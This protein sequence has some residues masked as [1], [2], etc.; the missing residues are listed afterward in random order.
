[1]I[2]ELSEDDKAA[3]L[4]VLT[5]RVEFAQQLLIAIQA[6][7][8]EKKELSALQIRQMASLGNSDLTRLLEKV[9]GKIGVSSEDAKKQIAKIRN[10]YTTAPLWAY[11]AARGEQVYKKNCAACHPR[12]GTSVPLGPGLKGSWRN[13]LD[14]FLENTIDPNAVVGENYRLTSVITK[15]GQIINGLLDSESDTTLILRTAEKTVSIPKSEID[16]RKLVD[17]SL[18][19]T[20][21]LDKL[22]EAEVIELLN[23]LLQRE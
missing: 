16:E 19:P 23:Y 15:S 9:W 7:T 2:P 3:A 1:L 14:Y 13:G 6:G 21:L 8:L 11:S 5:S 20:G 12:D 4:T 10:T 22:S 17:Q 18:M